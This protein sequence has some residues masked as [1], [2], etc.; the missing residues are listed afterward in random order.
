MYPED[1]TQEEEHIQNE[2][3]LELLDEID[4]RNVRL[5]PWWVSQEH[6]AQYRCSYCGYALNF[7][8]AHGIGSK[9]YHQY[10]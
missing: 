6:R 9:L 8:E 5:T 2:K 3:N 7:S 4:K 1:R 10:C